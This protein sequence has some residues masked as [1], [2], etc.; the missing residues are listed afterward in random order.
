MAALD[1]DHIGESIVIL[2]FVQAKVEAKSGQPKVA[3]GE[4]GHAAIRPPE[5]I[6][7]FADPSGKIRLII[8]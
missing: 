3:C 1:L 6:I 7:P 4:I 5:R 8:E 2:F